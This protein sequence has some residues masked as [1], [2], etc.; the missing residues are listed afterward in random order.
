MA[1]SQPEQLAAGYFEIP[2]GVYEKD[3]FLT[4]RNNMDTIRANSPKFNNE[5]AE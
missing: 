2:E 3:K 1:E 4:N 5:P